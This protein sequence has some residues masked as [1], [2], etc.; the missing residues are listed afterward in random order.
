MISELVFLIAHPSA[1]YV[2]L[3][4]MTVGVSWSS[5]I[6]PYQPSI[7]WWR[8][9]KIAPPKAIPVVLKHQW[10]PK[11]PRRPDIK[12]VGSHLQDL[13]LWKWGRAGE[14]WTSPQV[15]LM[16]LALVT[17]SKNQWPSQPVA[18]PQRGVCTSYFAVQPWEAESGQHSWDGW[19]LLPGAW[20]HDSLDY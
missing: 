19:K 12:R 2:N 4:H 8:N 7:F 17:Y 18:E 14:Y 5:E 16:L 15:L 10:G 1:R 11:S 20:Y 9:W 3:Y 13:A 6:L